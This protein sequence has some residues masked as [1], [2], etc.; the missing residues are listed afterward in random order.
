MVFRLPPDINVQEVY[1]HTQVNPS[2]NEKLISHS[3]DNTAKTYQIKKILTPDYRLDVQKY[4]D[5]S[6]L[7][8]STTFALQYGLSF[9]SIMSV[10]VHIGLFHGKEIWRRFRDSRSEPKDIHGKLYEKYEDV[11]LWWF[12]AMFVIMVG[13][14][15]ATILKYDLQLPVW[16]FFFALFMSAFFIVSS[17]HVNCA[18]SD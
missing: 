13:I 6:P 9:A 8:L 2:L 7:F 4:K 18:R 17:T 15:L 14:G 1:I 12:A 11:P 3:Y 5:Y 10:V 16:A